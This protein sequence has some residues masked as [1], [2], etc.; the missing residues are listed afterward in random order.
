MATEN[1]AV[2]NALTTF[3]KD[4]VYVSLQG[5]SSSCLREYMAFKWHQMLFIDTQSHIES[6]LISWFWVEIFSEKIKFFPTSWHF[7][8]S[9]V[10]LN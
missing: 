7:R 5:I 1:R 3:H 8:C 10:L 6:G 9:G 4:L 2:A